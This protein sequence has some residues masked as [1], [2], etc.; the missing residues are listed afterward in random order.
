MIIS[1]RSKYFLVLTSRTKHTTVNRDGISTSLTDGKRI[2]VNGG[3]SLPRPYPGSMVL[4]IC[5]FDISTLTDELFAK[6]LQRFKIFYLLVILMWEI[7][8]ITISANHIR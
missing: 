3:R 1:C 4:E 6:A 7:G 5:V 2:P 8:M